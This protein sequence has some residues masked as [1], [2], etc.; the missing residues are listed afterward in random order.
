MN[1]NVTTRVFL[2]V[3]GAAAAFAQ[4]PS[5][6]EFEV[7]TI[8]PSAEQPQGTGA[9][10]VRIDGAQVRWSGLS[11]RDYIAGAHEVKSNQVSGPDWLG[12]T[13]F[14]IAA[15][16]PAG[17]QPSQIPEM[18]RHLIEERFQVKVH[19][20]KKDFPVYALEVANG[21]L[22]MQENAPDP[23]AAKVDPKAPQTFAGSGSA[24]GISVT[25]GRGSSYTFS[26]NKFEAKGLTM[27]FLVG[28][29]EAFLDRP[30]VDMTQLKGKYDFVLNLTE[31]DYRIMLIR[32]AVNANVVLPPQA[33]RLLDGGSPVSLFDA[34]QK[35]GLRLDPRKAPLDLLVVDDARRTPTDN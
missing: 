23:E 34:I 35:I 1:M 11:L 21:G 25:L 31:E 7:A 26:N 8:R 10:G 5:T 13:R 14:D 30:I 29:L 15:T 20:D 17:S 32:S 16:L 12:S 2:M 24:Q 33:L 18:L 27:E 28:S 9:G 4:K 6:P 19:R 22:K 3:A